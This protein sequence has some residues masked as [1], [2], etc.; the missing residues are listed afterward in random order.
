MIVLI[1]GALGAAC[2]MMFRRPGPTVAAAFISHFVVDAICHDEPID[3][4]N[5]LRLDVIALDGLLLGLAMVLVAKRQGPFSAQS[6]GA[7]AA[8][9]PDAEH[10]LG[11]RRGLLEPPV[12][13]VFPH[14]IW[15]SRRISLGRQFLIGVAAWLALLKCRSSA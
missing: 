14:A 7:L 8:S 5:D 13:S 15:P 11:G 4:S 9:L 1:H 6:L 12:H 3:E 10:L 2:G